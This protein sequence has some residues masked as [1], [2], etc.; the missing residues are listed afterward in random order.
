M[1]QRKTIIVQA[2]IEDVRRGLDDYLRAPLLKQVGRLTMIQDA[3][4]DT[5]SNDAI[6]SIARSF[7]I[8]L[9]AILMKDEIATTPDSDGRVLALVAGGET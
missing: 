7:S 6:E 1:Q 2:P 3:V 4:I 8:P 9:V 5:M